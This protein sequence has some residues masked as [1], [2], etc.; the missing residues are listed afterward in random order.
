MF[1]DVVSQNRRRKNRQLQSGTG[2]S[3]SQKDPLER[4]SRHQ[5]S[6]ILCRVLNAASVFHLKMEDLLAA[7]LDIKNNFE[8][9]NWAFLQCVAKEDEIA[10]VYARLGTIEST[11]SA[12]MVQNREMARQ[13]T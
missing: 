8:L 10:S 3:T 6:N 1:T 2:T 9:Q 5:D 7:G 12:T 4:Y 13:L 11:F